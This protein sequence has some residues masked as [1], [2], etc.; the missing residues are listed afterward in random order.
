M[1]ALLPF[2]LSV[3]SS[4]FLTVFIRTQAAMLQ[5]YDVISSLI[6]NIGIVYSISYFAAHF[7]ILIQRFFAVS[8]ISIPNVRAY[9][10]VELKSH[11][12]AFFVL[13]LSRVKHESAV[14]QGETFISE[15]WKEK[16]KS[17]NNEHWSFRFNL[18]LLIAST[19]ESSP[20]TI[21]TAQ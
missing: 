12:H 21:N 8:E 17:S 14:V 2:S 19:Y 9:K 6:I 5:F 18:I 10:A 13:R 1:L 7:N 15:V 11:S 20:I 4:F 16:K 3:F